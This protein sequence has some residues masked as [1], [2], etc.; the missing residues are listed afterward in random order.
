MEEILKL[1]EKFKLDENLLTFCKVQAL[2][3]DDIEKSLSNQHDWRLRLKINIEYD[4]AYDRLYIGQWNQVPEEYRRLFLILSFLKAF[5]AVQNQQKQTLEHLLKALHVLDVGIIIGSGLQEASLVTEFAQLL[6]EFLV[7]QHPPEQIKTSTNSSPC[8]DTCDIDIIN[9]PSE[10]HFWTKYLNFHRPVKLTNCMT[11]WPAMKKWRDLN[12][13]MRTAGY[14]TVPIEL[15]KKYD[16]DDWSQGLFR[17]GEFL[18]RFISENAEN[19]HPGYLAQHDLF[20]QIPQLRKD[21]SIPDFCAIGREEPVIK[22][23]IGP[24]N[25]ISTMHTDDKHNILCQVLGEKLIILAS[26]ADSDNLY[27]YEG[28]LNNTSQID[29]ENLDFDEF[30]LTKNVKFYKLVLKAGEMLFIP[31]MWFHYVRSLS[32]SISISFWFEAEDKI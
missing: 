9:Q 13:F 26:P 27:Q 15:G 22:S 8:I 11:H 24:A 19:D 28:L 16:N 6:H 3:K 1:K 2:N 29:P 7:E 17:F 30:P 20:D 32:P 10:E 12:Y 23:W 4:L 5:S 31:K 21:F 18:K 25:T 14:R